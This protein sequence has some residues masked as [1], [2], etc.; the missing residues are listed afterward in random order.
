MI[1]LLQSLLHYRC[2][3]ELDRV[4]G[5]LTRF[6]VL[7]NKY[8]VASGE[9]FFGERLSCSRLA[10][11]L[12]GHVQV[13]AGIY[14]SFARLKDGIKTYVLAKMAYHLDR[15][16]PP[17]EPVPMEVDALDYG[18][19][20]REPS[21]GGGWQRPGRSPQ[22]QQGRSQKS[23]EQRRHEAEQRKKESDCHY[24]G[25]K[26]HYARECR[27]K[28][29]DEGTAEKQALNRHDQQRWFPKGKGKGKG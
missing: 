14:D 19:G 27:K 16:L 17:D 4:Q 20:R 3:D 1:T 25:K 8:E 15:V 22:L 11:P 7:A 21:S 28:A 10:E 5:S 13:N 24:C 6:E 23:E 18:G 2:P 29:R 9:T 26:G 12:R